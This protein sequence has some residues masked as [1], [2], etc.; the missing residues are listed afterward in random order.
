MSEILVVDDERTLREGMRLLLEGEG[1]G[2]RLARNG[3]A[4]L[5]EFREHLPDLVLLDVMMPGMSGF[6]VCEQIRVADAD[7]PILF[8]TARTSEADQVRAFG[9]GGDD[10]V[11]KTVDDSV[12]LARIRRAL[13]RR[14]E[15]RSNS[16]FDPSRRIRLGALTIDFD[17]LVISGSNRHVILTKSEA[18]FLWLLNSTPGKFFSIAEICDVVCGANSESADKAI[19]MIAYR[20]KRKLGRYGHLIECNRGVGYKVIL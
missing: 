9:L 16:D 10:Y 2:V 7:V 4:A 14:S 13:E 5:R 18:D 11:F 12:L 3:E 15:N 19:Y 17:T 6:R 1:Y 8:L 20:L